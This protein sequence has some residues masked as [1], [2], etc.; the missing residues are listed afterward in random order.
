MS[1]VVGHHDDDVVV[2]DPVVVDYLVGV[3]DIS[4]VSVTSPAL[5]LVG[6]LN[7]VL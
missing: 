1:D 6:I 3:T 2:R 5:S 7:T 4:L